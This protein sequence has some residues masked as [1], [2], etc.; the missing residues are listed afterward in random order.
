M[1]Q[2]KTLRF[3]TNDA[4]TATEKLVGHCN[5]YKIAPGEVLITERGGPCSG[6]GGWLSVMIFT[7]R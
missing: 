7:D 3:E 1:K 4:G 5:N 2:W 6:K